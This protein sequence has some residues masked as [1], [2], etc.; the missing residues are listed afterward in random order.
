MIII[1]KNIRYV[2]CPATN[3]QWRSGYSKRLSAV[4]G[5]G[6]AKWR[7]AGHLWKYST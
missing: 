2:S 6:S 1:V 7:R 3:L 5:Q 4:K